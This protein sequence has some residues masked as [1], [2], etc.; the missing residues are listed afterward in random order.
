MVGSGGREHALALRLLESPSV[1]EVILAPGNAGTLAPPPALAH[2]KLSSSREAP[3]T[4]AKR[5]NVDLVVVGPEGPLCDG[6]VDDLTREGVLT[7]GPSKLAAELEGSK[8]FMK[9]FA[10]RHGIPTAR[11]V[12]VR[13]VEELQPQVR[14]FEVPPVVKA[15]GLCAGKGVVVAETHEEAL[16]AAREMLSG[17][18]FGAAGATV[19]L[20]ERLVGDEASIHAICDGERYVLLHAA[21]DHKRIFDGDRGPNTGGMGT[22]APAPV[23]TP[24]VMQRFEAQVVIPTLRGMAAE[25]RP[26]RG[27][28]FAGIMVT[29]EQQVRLIEFNVRFGDPETQ[30]LMA[31]LE[32]DLAEVLAAAA[33][34]QLEPS[35]LRASGKHAVCVVLAAHGYPDTPRKGDVISG[36][37]AAG[38]LEGVNVLHAGTAL[39]AAGN[40]TVAGGRVLGVTGHGATLAEAHRL[41]YEAVRKIDFAGMQYRRDIAGRAG[42]KA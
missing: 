23:V 24:E 2:K 19:V 22:Y 25:G 12:V 15:D 29:A 18:R 3:L 14:S 33:R 26:F 8:A 27:T 9:G 38:Q 42:L 6:L 17:A 11:H 37:G 21:Q 40:V 7:Y 41:A 16:G 30:V 4:L 32:G 13:S 1:G 34:G 39:D 10:V 5:E 35:A 31:T 28:L 20:E 36:L